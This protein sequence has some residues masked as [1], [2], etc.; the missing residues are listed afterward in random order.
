[1][2][3]SSPRAWGT[4]T[5]GRRGQAND[6]FIPTGVGN[7]APSAHRCPAAA[8]HPHGRGEHVRYEAGQTA[9]PG[10]SPRAWGT[11]RAVHRGRSQFRFIPTGVGNTTTGRL[12]A[13][14]S[15]V[16]PHGRGE[17]VVGTLINNDA[18]GSSPRAWG[19]RAWI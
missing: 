8:V 4:P 15:T 5:G 3:G 7:T 13:S 11:P 16:H 17:H 9:Y 10:S 19:T 2:T 12:T 14:D 6:R 1:M 18:D